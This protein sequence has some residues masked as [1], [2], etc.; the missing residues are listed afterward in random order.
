MI[1]LKY[2]MT[3]MII[4]IL[5]SVTILLTS[6]ELIAF[7]MSN[8]R[9]SFEKHNI[10]EETGMDKDNFEHVITDLLSYLRNDKDV[11]DTVAVV[12]GE[13][14]VVFGERERLHMIDVKVFIKIKI[15]QK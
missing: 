5:L 7:S 13:E 11:L 12:K 4:G 3:Y 9:S 8:Y 1:K 15:K 2:L 6:T 14:R 10:S